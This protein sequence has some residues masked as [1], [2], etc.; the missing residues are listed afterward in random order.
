MARPP[1]AASITPKFVDG[2]R[3]RFVA[4]WPSFPMGG[5]RHR[6]KG[7]GSFGIIRATR[8]DAH[9]TNQRTRQRAWQDHL[10]SRQS[11]LGLRQRRC[12]EDLEEGDVDHR[13]QREGHA[14]L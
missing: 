14:P 11:L 4:T 1:Y 9:G 5:Q 13:K 12:A 10:T 6:P 8:M 3:D 2:R 7:A